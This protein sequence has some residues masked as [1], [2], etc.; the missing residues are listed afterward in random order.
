MIKTITAEELY[1]KM[2]MQ[3][4][5]L[6]LDVRA[7]DKYNQ[8][9]IEGDNIEGINIPKTKIFALEDE[10][11]IAELSNNKEIVITCTTGNSATRCANILS[12]RNYDVVVLEGGVTA[13]KEHI[14]NWT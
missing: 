4:E 9:H 3:E 8:F 10:E 12:E 5:L 11:N 14:R 13:W 1:K 7:E 2:Q 6:L